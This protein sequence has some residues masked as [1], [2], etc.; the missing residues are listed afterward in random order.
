MK[1]VPS[2]DS[3]ALKKN[4]RRAKFYIY[5]L[6]PAL[7]TILLSLMII[8]IVFSLVS[9]RADKHLFRTIFAFAFWGYVAFSAIRHSVL[10]VRSRNRAAIVIGVLF[11]LPA[12]IVAIVAFG[13]TNSV[14]VAGKLTAVAAGGFGLFALLHGLFAHNAIADVQEAGV[15]TAFSDNDF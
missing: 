4:V 13:S 10:F 6:I 14:Q 1:V 2:W 5:M 15:E 3:D 8:V 7:M 12:L 9:Y 11:L